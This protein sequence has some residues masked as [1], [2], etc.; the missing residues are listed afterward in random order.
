MPA[1]IIV[2]VNSLDTP[3][4]YIG[5]PPVCRT[6]RAHDR[7]VPSFLVNRR[8]ASFHPTSM[9]FNAA[10]GACVS[11]FFAMCHMKVY[12]DLLLAVWDAPVFRQFHEI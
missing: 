4:H 1:I 3:L 6:Q 7:G 8:A 11:S 10:V 5:P 9:R 12:D 2:Q